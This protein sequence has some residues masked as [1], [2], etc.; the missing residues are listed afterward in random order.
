MMES[1]NSFQNFTRNEIDYLKSK[2]STVESS[3]DEVMR[4]SHTGTD[5]Y[6]RQTFGGSPSK[7][8]YGGGGYSGGYAMN[9]T[10]KD[11]YQNDP[12]AA[13]Y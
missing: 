10:T 8:G 6:S 9:N 1:M 5:E 3:V 13:G 2:I 12:Y 4:I 11:Y 7:P